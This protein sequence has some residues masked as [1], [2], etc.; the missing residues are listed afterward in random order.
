ML[1]GGPHHPPPD[2]RS[3]ALLQATLQ[4]SA[5]RL[6]CTTRPV[7]LAPLAL[8]MD[9]TFLDATVFLAFVIAVIA[10][11]VFMSRDD[12]DG[13]ETSEDFFL[14]GRG[15]SWWLI[16]FSLI[17]ANISTE[18][19][20]GM[21]GQAANYVGLAV[22]S[23][24]WMAAVTLVVVAF[25]FLPTFLRTGIYTIPEYLSFRFNDSARTM[26]AGLVVIMYVAVTIPSV[27]YSGAL[28]VETLF[29]QSVSL[30]AGTW[31]IGVTA[32]VYVATGGLK[33]CAWADLLQG[34]AL[35]IGGAVILYFA[36]GKLGETE[37]A[38]LTTTADI[39]GL[40]DSAGG[41]EKFL[42]LNEH[43]L[44]MVLP[45][46]DTI[47]PWTA[48]V[49]G[50]WIPNFYYWG[51]N[52]YIIQRTLG[53][54]SLAHGQRGI[55]LAAG[56]KLIIPFVIVFPGIAAYNLYAGQMADAATKDTNT[57]L[58]QYEEAK[59]AGDELI[60]FP[61]AEDWAEQ[62]PRK[63]V[64]L[65]TWNEAV[66]SRAEAA[67]KSPNEADKIVK[68]K[69]D[70]AFALLV[71]QLVPGGSGLRGFILAAILGAVVSSLASMLNAASTIF[72]MDFFKKYVAPSAGPK[73]QVLTGRVCVLGFM[74]VG[75]LIAPALGAPQ[76]KG[77]FTFI[78]EFQGFLSPGV[79][80]LF[81]FGFFV[82]ATPRIA[83]VVALTSS[84]AVYGFLKLAFGDWAFLNRMAI[85]FG[86]V[87]AFLLALT[88]AMPRNEPEEELPAPKIEL[89]SCP[90]ARTLGIVVV[91]AT[92]G[93]YAVFW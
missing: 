44:H 40:A 52:Q 39:Q 21:S 90:T 86:V 88:I 17:A 37:V 71:S 69:Y 66:L 68:Y 72:T 61:F 78:Q 26:M 49:L 42:V 50:L 56:L 34:S 5:T 83:G 4:L 89:V 22:A 73:T 7:R 18:Q 30:Y 60:V 41:W 75:C 46:T 13:Q 36:I 33:A 62:H 29:P 12:G 65:A 70:T 81:L 20:V 14:A 55:I 11:G 87:V 53:S 74:V 1:P 77:I 58:A 91:L 6:V 54:H 16:G 45:A 3:S 9:I 51:L 92:L 57:V 76:F 19:F 24:E 35:I 93:L 23:Y 63:S 31:I 67:G 43:K 79:L 15:L 48:L 64:E 38:A 10:V 32:A 85:T 27:I 84:P 28:M 8:H 25:F 2:R 47:I 80:A 82:R 59:A